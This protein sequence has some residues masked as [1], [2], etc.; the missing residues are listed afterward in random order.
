MNQL[1]NR[2]YHTFTSQDMDEVWWYVAHVLAITTHIGLCF[3]GIVAFPLIASFN[4]QPNKFSFNEV[5]LTCGSLGVGMLGFALTS[6]IFSALQK[7]DKAEGRS[8]Y[9][10][11]QTTTII[12]AC[13]AMILVVGEIIMAK[14]LG[15]QGPVLLRVLCAVTACAA[16]STTLSVIADII[17]LYTFNREDAEEDRLMWESQRIQL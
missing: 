5:F 2:Y 15:R 10:H 13:S 4:L 9:F 6:Y 16:T 12:G 7:A 8:T 11:K 17:K 3:A 1:I 14:A